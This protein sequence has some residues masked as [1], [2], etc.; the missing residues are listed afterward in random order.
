M[1]Y[2]EEVLAAVIEQYGDP[3]GKIIVTRQALDYVRDN[4]TRVVR[5]PYPD[6]GILLEAVTE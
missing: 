1:R 4:G 2:D 6:G 3:E 5:R